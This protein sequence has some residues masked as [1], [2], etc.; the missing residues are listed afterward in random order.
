MSDSDTNSEAETW[1]LKDLLLNAPSRILKKLI[2]VVV[3]EKEGF[4]KQ[5]WER[6]FK[7][8]TSLVSGLCIVS[9][10]LEKQE[11]LITVKEFMKTCEG[12]TIKTALTRPISLTTAEERKIFMNYLT[13][14]YNSYENAGE[15]E[16]SASSVTKETDSPSRSTST[17]LTRAEKDVSVPSSRKRKR[18]AFSLEDIS[19]I[20]EDFAIKSQKPTLQGSLD[21]TMNQEG[22]AVKYTVAQPWSEWLLTISV[23]RT[24]DLVGEEK[25][26]YWRKRMLT[27]NG[28]FTS[29]S[30]VMLKVNQI[31]DLVLNSMKKQEVKRQQL[32]RAG[33]RSYWTEC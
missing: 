25:R 30:Q 15:T 17:Q 1:T 11:K 31:K 3:E 4:I 6:E 21:I 14:L 20:G 5:N 33:E 27:I 18:E 10:E 7:L 29:E 13:E 22:G 8:I 2:E 16:T 24:Q 26:N 19:S 9:E 28:S 23:T 32:Q 12:L